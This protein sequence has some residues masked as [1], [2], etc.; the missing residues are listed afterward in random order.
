MKMF[1]VDINVVATAY[2]IAEDEAEARELVAK[3]LVDTG[4]EL[5]EESSGGFVRGSTFETMLEEIA[6]DEHDTRVT[7]S[8]A[9]T[10]V[11]PG[12]NY[13]LEELEG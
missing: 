2:I 5:L 13:D 1:S 9:I 7:I 6:D 11:G 4:V 3:E 8:P 12:P 10:L